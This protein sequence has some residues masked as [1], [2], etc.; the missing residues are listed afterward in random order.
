M[1]S[2]VFGEIFYS[3]IIDTQTEFGATSFVLP[4]AS[5]VRARMVAV[6]SELVDKVLVGK[7]SRLFEA[8]HAFLDSDVDVLI[9]GDELV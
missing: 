6:R 9:G 3:K 5:G 4:K 2:I 1:I 8:V 7:D